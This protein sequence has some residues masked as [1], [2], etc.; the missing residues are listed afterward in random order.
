[1]AKLACCALLVVS[2]L[3]GCNHA[4]TKSGGAPSDLGDDAGA[5][6]AADLAVAD[7]M[8]V[9]DA[10][11]MA[12]AGVGDMAL[13]GAADMTT[14]MPDLANLDLALANNTPV[15][16]SPVTRASL[17]CPL[18]ATG[19]GGTLSL[20][21]Q[22]TTATTNGY[23]TL[24]SWAFAPTSGTATHGD[25]GTPPFGAKTCNGS[26][27]PLGSSF[28]YT[29]PFD[30]ALIFDG[31][32]FIKLRGN[33]YSG[34]A[35]GANALVVPNNQYG[36]NTLVVYDAT[37]TQISSLNLGAWD[38]LAVGS[39]GNGGF[40][41]AY[42]TDS[43]SG[44]NATATLNFQSY[45]GGS[46][47]AAE[48]VT[49][50]PAP[51]GNYTFRQLGVAGGAG[52]WA[53]S[54]LVPGGTPNVPLNVA[55]RG[56]GGTWTTSGSFTIASSPSG[57]A[58]LLAGNSSTLA[59]GGIGNG[60]SYGTS[61]DFA[62]VYSGGSWSTTVL[63][64]ALANTIYAFQ[65]TASGYVMVWGGGN[66]PARASVFG[67][68]SWSTPYAV[69]FQP[70]VAAGPAGVAVVSTASG[71]ASQ[72]AIYAGGAWSSSTLSSGPSSGIGVAATANGFVADYVELGAVATR[73]WSPS[74]WGTASNRPCNLQPGAVSEISL[75]EAANGHALAFWSQ[76]DAGQ[77]LLFA[78][79]FDGT[80]WGAPVQVA[81][82]SF[83]F[84]ASP[85]VV[86][87]PLGFMLSWFSYGNP[88]LP[89]TVAK[90]A[91]AST[92]PIALAKSLSTPGLAWS[93]TTL[94][95]VWGVPGGGVASATSSDGATWS[96][97]TT[98]EA[99]P[100][101]PSGLVGN[102][103]GFFVAS[104]NS[105]TQQARA[106]V[107]QAGSWSAP[108]AT[109]GAIHGCA[110]AAASATF[111]AVCSGTTLDAQW[112]NGSFSD[113]PLA[114]SPATSLALASD[115]TSYRL[116][117]GGN[118]AMLSNGAWSSPA[119][120]TNL[121]GLP[122]LGLVPLGVSWELLTQSNQQLER[123]AV[124]GGAIFGAPTAIESTTA[125]IGSP[126][127]AAGPL[128]ADAVWTE[129]SAGVL[130]ADVLYARTGL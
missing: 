101:Q 75:A 19:A 83:V 120:E 119:V 68:G 123:A 43:G 109:L 88:S 20:W 27:L 1:M 44:V 94:M 84:G 59:V 89:G 12:M 126:V 40:G 5:S 37:G 64:T 130:L 67:G 10:A 8:T 16:L 95:A 85:Q 124:A 87:T 29:S 66:Q 74:A 60:A 13:T 80:Q 3:C 45:S 31:T 41:V 55:V 81:N 117:Y 86:A 92:T 106:R 65:G 58:Y 2:L 111:L 51:N 104:Y 49:T 33:G 73:T 98:V 93:G 39:D 34:I 47:S 48:T 105:S 22:S 42:L 110:L 9:A 121:A 32:R 128:R 6:D 11:D 46:W 118:E 7:D 122:T 69:G 129:A 53:V 57:Y 38:L 91:G 36:G 30:G 52:T 17:S 35:S 28:F 77:L 107:Y 72:A 14:V 82:Q 71:P 25:Y 26:L 56:G 21:T 112:W 24:D 63:E 62:S 103:S 100:W 54:W 50:A 96:T 116:E 70:S 114:S 23:N 108:S 76:F 115:G 90:W 15:V 102:G 97:P 78:A 125:T 99:A 18:V 113:V 127:L 61:S 79:E 4:G